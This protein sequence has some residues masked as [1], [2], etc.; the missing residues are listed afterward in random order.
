MAGGMVTAFMGACRSSSM[1]TMWHTS[2]TTTSC[3]PLSTRICCESSSRRRASGPTASGTSLTKVGTVLARTTASL[4]VAFPTQ[5]RVPGHTSL[6]RLA[7][8]WTAISQSWQDPSGMPASAIPRGVQ[9]QTANCARFSSRAPR[10]SRSGSIT[11]GTVLGLQGC[12]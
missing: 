7:T 12:R 2:M 1:Q 6:T 5:S 8:S 9:S 10:M 11:S 4:W 3:P